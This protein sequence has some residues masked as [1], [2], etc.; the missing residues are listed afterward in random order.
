MTAFNPVLRRELTER[1][2]G[3]RTFVIITLYVAGLALVMQLL[4]LIGRSQLESQFGFGGFG[5]EGGGVSAGP[6]LGRFLF[7]NLLAF[8]LLLVVFIA[9]GYAA[10]QIAGERERR[11]LP[12]LQVTL[13]RPVQ[14]VLG[15]LGSGLAWLVL[16]IIA[17]MPFGAA[18]FFLGGVSVID[19]LSGALYILVIALAIAAASLGISAMVK[20]TVSAVVVTYGLVL[21][22]VVGSIFGSLVE[23]YV[24]DSVEGIG[25]PTDN[26]LALYLNPF[27]GLTDAIGVSRDVGFGG[28]LP[29]VLSPFAYFL[30]TTWDVNAVGMDGVVVE[31]FDGV[32]RGIVVVEQARPKAM[33]GVPDAVPLRDPGTIIV[34]QEAF[35]VARGE[36]G[37]GVVVEGPNAVAFGPGG[38]RFALRADQPLAQQPGR[39]VQGG[40]PVWQLELLVYSALGFLGL[41]VAH[42]RV[43]PRRTRS[44]VPHPTPAPST[45]V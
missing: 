4:Y 6:A 25:R 22:L 15:K 12:L 44:S 40:E 43:R 21:T 23:A 33:L 28:G 7:E 35:A 30:P 37:I 8:V 24:R 41:L 45:V 11:T 10:A 14:I 27:Y 26:P 9:P 16:L 17:A 42:R 39:A 38:D 32:G 19:L 34:K 1:W 20:R 13:L 5:F 36:T 2:R 29:S 31:E 18:A 3:R